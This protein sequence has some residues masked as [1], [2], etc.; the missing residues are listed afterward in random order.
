MFSGTV[1]RKFVK[2][3]DKTKLSNFKRNSHNIMQAGNVFLDV[4][5]FLIFLLS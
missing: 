1:G 5:F 4:R 2:S 3:K